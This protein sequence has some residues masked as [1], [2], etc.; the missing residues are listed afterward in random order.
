MLCMYVAKSQD[1]WN[2]KLAC[3]EFEINN[4]THETTEYFPV[5]LI[6]GFHPRLSVAILPN[7]RLPSPSD[8]VQR[9]LQ[10]INE[11]RMTHMVAT[12]EHAQYANRR[13]RDVQ[14]G[15]GACP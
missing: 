8:F 10:M 13:R 7:T 1:D 11:A 2:E 14:F 4:A 5:M 6:Y 3:T 15:A 9:M 12:N